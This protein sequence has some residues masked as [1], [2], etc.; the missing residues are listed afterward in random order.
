MYERSKRYVPLDPE[1]VQRARE[2]DLFSYLSIYDPGNL[3]K[4]AAGVYCTREHDS[5]KISNGKWFW[6][7]RGFGGVSA[8]D[9]L[10]KVKGM[11][12]VSA[13][14]HLT[15]EQRR[16]Y[17]REEKRIQKAEEK[18]KVLLLPEK[19]EDNDKVKSYLFQRGISIPIIE[20]CIED[21]IL[22][23]SKLY[24]N[25][26][27]IGKDYNQIPKYAA[28]RSTNGS[29]FKI[30]ASGSDKR[31]S[32]RMIAER[33]SDTLHLFEGAIDLLSYATYVDYMDGDYR[34][35]NLLSLAGVYQPKNEMEES[36]I[37]V[38]VTEFLKENPHIKRIFLHF[39]NDKAG[40]KAAVAIK[41][42]LEKAYEVIDD[43][44]KTGKDFNDFWMQ[45]LGI[46]T[47]KQS[48]ERE[49]TGGKER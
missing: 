25:A 2:M 4:V 37:P 11:D 3:V 43:P 40:R 18:P 5:L 39:D 42:Q 27:F 10:I 48:K 33:R 17:F 22:Y 35:E 46:S 26:V 34:N 16:E 36:K 44:P 14:E 45:Q 7:S 6:W 23:E 32:F 8:L 19:N 21:G 49:K 15:G 24:H 31:F 20:R 9:Y 1:V 12:F 38:A 47:K 30:D 41:M 28:C 29:N 13:V